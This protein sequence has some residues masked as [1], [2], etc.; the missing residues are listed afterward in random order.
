MRPSG[1]EPLTFG[2][3]GRR[4]I[5]LSYGRVVARYEFCSCL[6]AA[7]HSRLG[8]SPRDARCGIP[9]F[10]PRRE[11]SA[12][13]VGFEPTSHLSAATRFPIAFFQPLRHLSIVTKFFQNNTER[14][15]FEPTRLLRAY[16]FSGPADSTSSRTSPRISCTL[17][18]LAK[19][20]HM[21]W[22]PT[23]H[24]LEIP[25]DFILPIER[26][27]VPSNSRMKTAVLQQ[28]VN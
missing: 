25:S 7:P 14:V 12:E 4:S 17:K 3:A 15:G 27:V 9:G 2:S 20:P 22:I 24:E 1:I 28:P 6:T 10:F 21:L 8:L 16:R 23:L 11:K 5:Q 13:R 26:D 18:V 19:P